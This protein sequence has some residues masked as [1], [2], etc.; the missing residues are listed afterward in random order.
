MTRTKAVSVRSDTRNRPR[1]PAAPY[2]CVRSRVGARTA[3]VAGF[4][5]KL[6]D[7]DLLEFLED[8]SIT[9]VGI[10]APFGWP[11][12]FVEA[13]GIYS[14]KGEWPA[15]EARLLTLR[16]TDRWVRELTGRDPLSVSTDKISFTAMRCARLLTEYGQRWEPVDR[17][18]AGRIVEVY[19]AAALR[20]W[21]LEPRGV[22]GIKARAGRPSPSSSRSS[23][24]RHKAGFC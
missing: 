10:D 16:A 14:E 2:R 15:T 5:T 22:Q 23:P 6:A 1:L 20:Q 7:S 4:Y 24:R 19:P 9:K 3:T 8:E 12:E 17:S 13:L 18:G 21:G 11:L